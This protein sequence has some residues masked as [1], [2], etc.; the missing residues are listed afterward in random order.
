VAVRGEQRVQP[1]AVQPERL[2][3]AD[4]DLAG[5]GVRV[6]QQ[7]VQEIQVV[8]DVQEARGQHAHGGGVHARAGR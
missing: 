8:A 3:E 2:G 6:V 5:A 4:H 7:V 1:G